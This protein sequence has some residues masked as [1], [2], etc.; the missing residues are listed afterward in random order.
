MSAKV[1]TDCIGQVIEHGD[2]V[3]HGFMFGLDQGVVL[4]SCC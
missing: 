3:V 4:Q 2:C 1:V